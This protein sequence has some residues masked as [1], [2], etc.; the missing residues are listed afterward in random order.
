MPSG[1]RQCQRL[2]PTE[3]IHLSNSTHPGRIHRGRRGTCSSRTVVERWCDS[4][5]TQQGW[6]QL[7][8]GWRGQGCLRCYMHLTWLVE[9]PENGEEDAWTDFPPASRRRTFEVG[10]SDRRLARTE[11]AI[12]PPTMMK[13]KEEL[14]SASWL[15]VWVSW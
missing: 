9:H 2:I 12:P 1:G 15:N 8:L 13:S 11:P 7:D 14:E 3:I 5:G 6:C 4:T 10:F